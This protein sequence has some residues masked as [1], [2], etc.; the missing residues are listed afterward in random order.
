MNRIDLLEFN[1]IKTCNL[2]CKGC[3]HFST[4]SYSPDI[5]SLESY[6]TDL[7]RLKKL[8]IEIK[9]VGLLGGEPLLVSNIEN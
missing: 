9:T 5:I 7:S 8:G 4:L 1:V 2:N 6:R 3:D